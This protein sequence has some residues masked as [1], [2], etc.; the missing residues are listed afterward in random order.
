MKRMKIAALLAAAMFLLAGCGT[1]VV[2]KVGGSKVTLPE[3]QFYLSNVKS[4]MAGTELSSDEDWQTKEIEGKKAIDLAKERALDNAVTNVA[5]VE[6]GKKLNIKLSDADKKNITSY[7]TR[8]VKSYGG[9]AQ[10]KKFLKENHLTDK[11]FDMFCESMAYSDNLTDKILTDEPI[12]DNETD[13][14]F[15]EHF[16]RAKHVL[17]LTQDMTTQQP[18][19]PEQQEAARAK[20]EGIYQRAMSGES[21]EALVSEYSEDPGSA[22][23]PD[24][25]VFTDGMMVDEFTDG[26]DSVGVGGIT[27]VKSSY[28]YHIIKRYALDETPE[29]YQKFLSDN[30]QTVKTN[31]KTERLSKQMELW[32]TELGIELK[33]NEEVYNS[34]QK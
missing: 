29:L 18:Y 20:A 15:K 22:S 30:E 7:K 34:I 21:F 14:Y 24:G 2:V 31:L 19:P 16:R 25:Y 32:K 17:I 8:L 5:Y 13:A 26:V 33:K 10:Y 3:F 27:M 1:D 12:T 28:G 23:N 11:F 4:Q 6:V 9:D